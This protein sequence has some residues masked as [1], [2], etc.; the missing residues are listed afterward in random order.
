MSR[1]FFD[2]FLELDEVKD[3]INQVSNSEEEKEELNSLVDGY[4]TTWVF[5]KVLDKVP[6]EKHVEFMEFFLNNPHDEEAVF[7]IITELSGKDIRNELEKDSKDLPSEILEGLL[8]QDEVN[9]ETR[10]PIK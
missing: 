6:E 3:L 9:R 8:P 4:V 1:L 7:G 2:N 5:D 10:L